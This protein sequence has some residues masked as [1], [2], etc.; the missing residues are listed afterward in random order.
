MKKVLFFVFVLLVPF[1]IFAATSG[2]GTVTCNVSENLTGGY[3]PSQQFTVTIKTNNMV[4]GAVAL[5][6]PRTWTPL[7]TANI[8]LSGTATE[9]EYVRKEYWLGD[10]YY[11]VTATANVDQT[12]IFDFKG[13][14]CGATAGSQTFTWLTAD[15]KKGIYDMAAISSQPSVYLWSANK[16]VAVGTVG[17]SP[18]ALTSD[19]N[20]FVAEV[21]WSVS[22]VYGGQLRWR[23]VQ[24]TPGYQSTPNPLTMT[25]STE[26]G[27]NNA[28]WLVCTPGVYGTP[29]C[30]NNECYAN[31]AAAATVG[32]G[33]KTLIYFGHPTP[34]VSVT[35]W[36]GSNYAKNMRIDI[37][38][39]ACRSAAT[40]TPVAYPTAAVNGNFTFLNPTP[41]V[42]LT[43]TYADNKIAFKTND[44]GL[45]DAKT[46][47]LFGSSAKAYTGAFNMTTLG[48]YDV[49][50]IVTFRDV[51]NDGEMRTNTTN[52]ITEYVL[53]KNTDLELALL[54]G[55][56]VSEYYTTVFDGTAG[57][58]TSYATAQ[59]VYKI[60][61]IGT[62][63]T[64]H[65]ARVVDGD[66]ATK[67]S[68]LVPRLALGLN[69]KLDNSYVLPKETFETW[70][71]AQGAPTTTTMYLNIFRYP[72][73]TR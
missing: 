12:I 45:T 24:G 66:T 49:S 52:T 40:E 34:A 26:K 15:S 72:L 29:V 69:G 21:V 38:A 61:A 36:H 63:D 9:A 4:S 58:I 54:R 55:D 60:D 13:V 1:G 42:V 33:N 7:A 53:P 20:P 28:S 16:A 14:T 27:R 47:Y 71:A 39:N 5:K 50:G 10:T 23:L 32:I 44:A 57:R 68:L 30:E 64:V 62:T 6:W 22:P 25:S 56:A 2:N 51:D 46:Q 48:A 17:P 18:V 35:P 59:Y 43:R 41:T 37:M 65:L 31:I 11:I 73:P 8:S 19:T 70:Y 3:I 67:N